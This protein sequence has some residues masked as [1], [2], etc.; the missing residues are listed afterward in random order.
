MGIA[1]SPLKMPVPH[2]FTVLNRVEPMPQINRVEPMPHP[3]TVLNR[4]EPMP[5]LMSPNLRGRNIE[6]DT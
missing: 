1:L 4:V 6:N 5:E 3:F 2:P